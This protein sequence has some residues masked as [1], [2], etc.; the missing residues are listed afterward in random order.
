MGKSVHDHR[1]A[2]GIARTQN[3]TKELFYYANEELIFDTREDNSCVIEFDLAF[4]GKDRDSQIFATFQNIKKT[5][6]R[7]S[8]SGEQYQRTPLVRLSLRQIKQR[9]KDYQRI[10]KDHNQLNLAKTKC[11]QQYPPH[12][13]R[14]S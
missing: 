3:P 14:P 11:Y 9:I 4:A 2:A 5:E 1:K 6:V 12:H 10:G 13:C 8:F 7:T